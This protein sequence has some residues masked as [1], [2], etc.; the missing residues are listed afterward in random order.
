[1]ELDNA[2]LPNL[3]LRK[4]KE[5]EEDGAE[6]RPAAWLVTGVQLSPAVPGSHGGQTLQLNR[7]AQAWQCERLLL[8]GAKRDKD[9][10]RPMG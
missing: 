2:I 10:V 3:A 8:Q 1:M 4:E 9:L 6:G 5:L 7:E